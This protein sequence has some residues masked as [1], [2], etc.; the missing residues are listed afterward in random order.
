MAVAWV[1][2]AHAL[3][4]AIMSPVSGPLADRFDRRRILIVSYLAASILTLCMWWVAEA[5]VALLQTMLFLRVCVSSVGS[6]ARTASIPQVVRRDELHSANALLGLTWSITF[7]L[8]LALGGFAVAGLGPSGRFY[9]TFYVSPRGHDLLAATGTLARD[10]WSSS[11]ETWHLRH[12]GCLE[13]CQPSTPPYGHTLGEVS[14]DDGECGWMGHSESDRCRTDV[15][16]RGLRCPRPDAYCA[17]RWNWR[18]TLLPERLLLVHL[19]PGP[20]WFFWAWH[21]LRSP[22]IPSLHGWAYSFGA[23]EAGIIGFLQRH[24]SNPKH[25]DILWEGF[26]D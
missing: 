15:L 11:A 10:E 16:G 24:H 3:P 4:M 1:L 8:G 13:I 20:R 7:A 26:R 23:V 6:T 19:S 2:A 12:V 17:G 18:G 9:S 5:S 22:V 14:G 25:R 21:Y